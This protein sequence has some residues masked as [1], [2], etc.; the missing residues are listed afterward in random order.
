VKVAFLMKD[1]P[2][3]EQRIPRELDWVQVYAGPDGVYPPAMLARLK[4][5]DALIGSI[6]DPVTEPLLAAAPRVRIVQRMGV[7]YDNVDLDAAARRHIPVCNLGD[8]NKD[9]L[10]EHGLCLMLALA[11]RLVENH[12]F[13]ARGDWPGA[14]ALCDDTYELQGKT[15]GI[16][17]FG[18]SG[19]ELAR[20]AWVFGMH[21]RYFNRS[22]VDARL[23]EAM[24]AQERG[25]EAL[26]AESDFLS[27]N[28]SL[29]PSTRG[30][31]D[32]RLLDLMRP[33]AY[34]INLARG[35]IVDEQALADRLN[36]GRL[37]GAGLDAF[38]LEPIRP[39]NPLL[40][41]KH[42]VLTSHIAGTTREC[43]D[44]EVGWALA[45]VRRFVEEGQTPRWIVNGVKAGA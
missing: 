21:I 6:R 18:K 36:A 4:D 25:L 11:R 5:V 29:N 44:R 43:T 12:N 17:G 40:H 38:S 1:R 26:F 41:A 45:N 2:D 9:A 31:V 7:G 19:Y 32:G 33:G 8:I 23:R 35:G 3:Y 34:L 15:L 24:D 22:P 20:R 37:G 14:R 27:V 16:L 39:D 28:V 10:G 30:L 13:I 42:V